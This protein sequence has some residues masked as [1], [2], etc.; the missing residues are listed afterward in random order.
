MKHLYSLISVFILSLSFLSAQSIRLQPAEYSLQLPEGFTTF[1]VD[2]S[3]VML[4]F[5]NKLSE[6][7]MQEFFAATGLFNSFESSWVLPFPDGVIAQFKE[8]GS[9]LTYPEKL[10]WLNRHDA[11]S[12]SAPV[13]L[14]NNHVQQAVY[15]LFYVR[16]N[17]QV[18]VSVLQEQARLLHFTIEKEYINNI[19]F[20]RINKYSAGNAFEIARYLQSLRTIE[21]AEPDFVYWAK[22]ETN[23][24]LY[25]Q[26]WHLNNTGTQFSGAV[27]GADLDMVNAWTLST[28]I[29]QIKVAILDCFGSIAQFS[30]SDFSFQVA[31][32]ATGTGFTATG[33]GG[34]AHGINCGGLIGASTNN[35]LGVAGIAYNA[36]VYAVKIGT[37]INSS[38]N[39]NTTGNSIS[40][41]II[42]AYQNAHI[43]SNSNSLG[44][45]SSLIDNAITNC[46]TIG[47]WG[48]GA[49]F[50]SS[51]GNN[52]SSTISYPSSNTNTI[53]VGA[54]T[55]SDSRASFSNYGTGL[56]IVAPGE[57]VYST[58]IAGTS[59]Y[60]ASDY[61]LFSGTSAAC[62]VAAGIMALIL[63]A[64]STLT[65]TQARNI[66]ETSCEKTGGYTYNSGISGQPN[67]T[68]STN[69][70]YGRI[71]AYNA[72]LL[73]SNTPPANDVITSA[74]VLTPGATCTTISGNLISATESIPPSNCSGAAASSAKDV[75]YAF[76]PAQP[77]VSIYCTG[78]TGTDIV[79]G[80]YSGTTSSPV[81]MSCTDVTSMNETEVLH[82][83]NLT[84]GITYYI[85]VYDFNQNTF[86]TNFD[87]CIRYTSPIT[88]N[89]ISPNQSFC[90]GGNAAT[91]TGSN[92]SGGAGILLQGYKANTD[93][94]NLT[95]SPG[96][97]IPLNEDT[98]LRG[99]LSLN[100]FGHMATATGVVF[101]NNYNVAA[102]K[103][104]RLE[105][106]T[107]APTVATD[108]LRFD[109]A[110]AA[111]PGNI[112]SLVVY[113]S[114]GTTYARITGWGSS[115]TVNTTT[116]ITTAAAQSST[117][118]PS[119]AQWVNKK[120][121]VPAGTTKIRFE[122]Y[123]DFGNRLYIDNIRLDSTASTYSYQWIKSTTSAG[124]GYSAATGTSNAINYAP[125]TVTQTTWY[126]RITYS[127]GLAD[128]SAAVS[129]TIHASPKAGFTVNNTDQYLTG[130]SFGFVDT[131]AN[132]AS[133]SWNFGNNT[134][135]TTLN[136]TR[137]YAAA[138]IYNVK[139]KVTTPQGCQ[140]SATRQVKVYP[141]A[142]VTAGNSMTFQSVT[143]TSMQVSW[144]NGSGQS[145]ILVAHAGSAVNATPVKGFLYN[146]SSQM[147]SG[148]DFG[149][150]N[151]V[152]YKG[153]G[154]AVTVTGLSH[155]TVYYFALIEF[156]G[157][158]TLTSYQAPV[159]LTGNNATLLPVKWLSFTASAS[160]NHAML[161]WSTASERNNKGFTIERWNVQQRTWNAIGFVNGKGT[162]NNSSRY[163]FTDWNG[164]A[165]DGQG[166]QYRIAQ[167]DFD[168]QTDYSEIRFVYPGKQ[169]T[170]TDLLVYPNPAHGQ[171]TLNAEQ[172]IQKV[173]IYNVFGMP[174][175]Q[176]AVADRTITEID[177]RDLP[178][179]IYLLEV[180]SG[181]AMK[182]AKIV[183]D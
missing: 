53:S 65:Q 22:M 161:N 124:T 177:V 7:D 67:G 122:F 57:N 35:A 158:T 69:T 23:D 96:W 81:L 110:H 75:W 101:A 170:A 68:W 144:N 133:R 51:S 116:G 60:S 25:G 127:S 32:D 171:F 84:T 182:Q 47:R 90:S 26:Q 72:L 166:K 135:S 20:C 136:P 157:D 172:T 21:F 142:P 111:Y 13:L 44:S 92:V 85:R 39:W 62:P 105:T 83:A 143:T 148:Y 1:K 153:T 120:L 79:L 113:A 17:Q 36:S 152:V 89:T 128:T 52:S 162:Y 87:I 49:P 15:D 150:G 123:S 58:D 100:S 109:V 183:I 64:D 19:Y 118:V 16:L 145:R 31:Y 94:H 121:V 140:D 115:Q 95:L 155:S 71:N 112:D 78:G 114:N 6:Q 80:A 137:A 50:F 11:V 160:G 168:G 108:T 178:K 5:N 102:G 56:D 99:V 167:T 74:T 4:R 163:T 129:V 27:A 42:W 10:E 46:V 134:T 14:Y 156:N 40:D 28:G 151:Y 125:G 2:E 103:R 175:K 149:S 43:V 86:T 146:A 106:N 77:N 119:N 29:P 173:I 138:G 97:T 131:T 91:L 38:G 82:L 117:F 93:F 45:S 54:S 41:G 76:V 63:S 12:Y 30:H 176:L 174:V 130:N 98:L 169:Y 24:P 48:K 34:D 104:A 181:N 147:G 139:L 107:F 126:K 37:I 59:G 70:G 159:Y 3:K 180:Q 132:V 154:S 55:A 66:I 179:G 141:D 165:G 9:K 61:F 8:T 33:F 18:P 73:A 164:L 88:N